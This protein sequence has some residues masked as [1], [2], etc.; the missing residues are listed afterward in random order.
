MHEDL[1][2]KWD[3]GNDVKLL[4]GLLTPCWISNQIK[5]NFICIVH[6]IPGGNNAP[7]RR[8]MGGL[9]TLVKRHRFPRDKY[10]DK[11]YSEW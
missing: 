3:V 8:K 7:H 1:G 4:Q 11:Y 5:S 2:R 10:T 9:P 6:F